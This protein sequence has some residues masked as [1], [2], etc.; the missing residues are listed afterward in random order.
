[1]SVEVKTV[2]VLGTGGTIAGTADSAIDSLGYT[3]ARL[4]V[5]QLASGIA[6]VPGVRVIS[7]QV[8]QVDSKDMTPEIWRALAL[9]CEHW[10]ARAEVAG[11]VITHGTDTLEETAYFLHAALAPAKPVVLTSAMRP[12]T[13]LQAD[14]P[15]NLLDAVLVASAPGA[16]GVVT[17]ASGIIHGAQDV[18]KV[19]PWRLDAFCSGDGGPLGFIEAGA[20]RMVRA[21]PRGDE[22]AQ[23]IMNRV[24]H[25]QAWPRVEILL[26]FVGA[27]GALTRMLLEQGVQGLVVAGA[28]NGSLS[29][30][31]EAALIEARSRGITVVRTTRCA[32]GRVLGMETDAL[33]AAV[34]LS[35]V[36][37]R[38]E[39]MLHLL[40]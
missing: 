32:F 10:I 31:L 35:A 7:E 20:I 16:R 40:E 33:P 8:A 25:A 15:Q 29:K 36:K 12:A 37:T 13:S 18:A 19:H 21:W 6:A 38:V 11:L 28:G 27:D 14:G 22:R 3:A 9:R 17:V 26:S 4:G 2:V 5:D 34:G 30:P 1:M 24:K 23:A 39:L